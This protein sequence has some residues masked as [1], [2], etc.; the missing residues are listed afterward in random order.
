MTANTAPNQ[1]PRPVVPPIED[2]GE[3]GPLVHARGVTKKFGGLT[4]V[5]NVDFDIPRGSIVSLI[6]PNGA[7]KTTFFNMI[8]GYY[9]PTTGEISFDGRT[10]ASSAS[11]K[12]R[13]KKPHEVTAMGIGRTFQNIRLFGAM[14]ALD[15]VRVGLNVH[16]KSHWW[17][18][19]LRT[20]A[21]LREEQAAI[22]EAMG[23]LDLVNLRPRA[24]TWARN[25]PYGDQRRLEIARALATRPKLLLLDEPTAGMNNSETRE[26][27]D[28]IRKLRAELG[29][30]VLLIEHD[31]RVVMGISDRVTVLD[32]GEV[33]AEGRPEE[34][35]ADKRVIEAYLGRGAAEA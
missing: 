30:T 32:Y 22:D 14:S 24:E 20:P 10:I 34:V 19:V 31:M 15:N 21:M 5:N 7:G 3:G 16:L 27:T 11:G 9:T 17:D 1:D 13:S 29:L 12:I 35:R 18:S 26:M 28:F 25:L 4:A 2:G 8:T 6:G 23:L 33:I